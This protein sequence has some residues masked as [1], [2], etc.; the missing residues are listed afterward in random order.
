MWNLGSNKIFIDFE[1]FRT[2]YK[3]LSFFHVNHW[4]RMK[5]RVKIL[6]KNTEIE[7]IFT[8]HIKEY[9]TIWTFKINN[10]TQKIF[11]AL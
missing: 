7:S 6:Q 10:L 4:N 9:L 11:K 1:Y 8:G 2:I 3:N 5:C